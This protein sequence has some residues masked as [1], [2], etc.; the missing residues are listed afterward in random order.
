MMTSTKRKS[1][2]TSFDSIFVD[3][4]CFPVSKAKQFI[5]D[6]LSYL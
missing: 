6:L 4:C 5:F 3:M 1:I 2:S